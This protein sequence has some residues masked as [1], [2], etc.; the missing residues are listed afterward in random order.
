M[1]R[2]NDSAPRSWPEFVWR[3]LTTPTALV[4][5]L[6]IVIVGYVLLRIAG[7][8]LLQPL[9]GRWNV[10]AVPQRPDI[11]KSPATSKLVFLTTNNQPLDGQT[12]KAE[13]VNGPGEDMR[14]VFVV[15][16]KNEGV[17]GRFVVKIYTS[18][19]LTLSARST[20]EA[21]FDYEN[22]IDQDKDMKTL[23]AGV[24]LDLTFRIKLVTKAPPPFGTYPAL[25]KA[26]YGEGTAEP[27]RAKFTL[28]LTGATGSAH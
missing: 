24:S 11:S 27:T 12:V 22:V 17:Q 20:D 15:R 19:P 18:D 26:Y 10:A 21:G 5:V 9:L 4:S 8:D 14:V 28:V 13:L 1:P 7:Y 6:F 2:D 25:L 3:I 23:R 16:E